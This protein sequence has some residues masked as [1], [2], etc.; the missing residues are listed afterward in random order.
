MPDASDRQP[1]R[2]FD[3][4]SLPL[5]LRLQG[6]E[7]LDVNHASRLRMQFLVGQQASLVTQTQFA[8]AKAAALMTLMGLVALNGP[9]RIDP[10]GPH[11]DRRDRAFSS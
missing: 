10:R 11:G 9:V 8:D 5:D 7:G 2:R 6:S 1:D 3:L 4:E